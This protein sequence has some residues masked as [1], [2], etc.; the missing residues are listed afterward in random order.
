MSLTLRQRQILSLMLTHGRPVVFYGGTRNFWWYLTSDDDPDLA[1][2]AY[3]EPERWLAG[4]GL[5]EA[6][7]SNQRGRWFRLTK[8]GRA[9]AARLRSRTRLLNDLGWYRRQQEDQS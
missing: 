9:K 4:R 6:S 2:Q 8:L 1:I 7:L 5:I 3:Q